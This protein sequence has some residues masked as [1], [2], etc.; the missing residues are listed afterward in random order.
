MQSSSTS[1][2]AGQIVHAEHGVNSWL[3][4]VHDPRQFTMSTHSPQTLLDELLHFA[5]SPWAGGHLRQRE[6][7]MPSVPYQPSVH[8]AQCELVW[9]VQSA[10]SLSPGTHVR[11]G[12]HSSSSPPGDQVPMHELHPVCPSTQAESAGHASPASHRSQIRSVPESRG[13]PPT[14]WTD[15][16]SPGGQMS[17]QFLMSESDVSLHR[18]ATY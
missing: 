13:C 12:L 16:P 3:P 15:S 5:V 17:V 8:S 4:G 9:A 18:A 11:Q 14:Q 2:P 1:F 6:Q 7:V 10:T